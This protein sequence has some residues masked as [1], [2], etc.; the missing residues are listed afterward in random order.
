[1][2]AKLGWRFYCYEIHSGSVEKRKFGVIVRS[3][4]NYG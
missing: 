3:A 4:E 1:M 2:G